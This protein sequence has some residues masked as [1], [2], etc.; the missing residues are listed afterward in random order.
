MGDE[1]GRGS[2][3]G[4]V[5]TQSSGVAAGNRLEIPDKLNCSFTKLRE[6]GMEGRRMCVKATHHLPLWNDDTR[7]IEPDPKTTRFLITGVFPEYHTPSRINIFMGL[8]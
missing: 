4:A 5:W 3:S 7:G 8:F 6:G 1:R 2:V